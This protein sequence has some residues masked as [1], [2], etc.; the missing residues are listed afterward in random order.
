MRRIAERGG[1]PPADE[2]VGTLGRD[3][4]LLPLEKVLS[5]GSA[6]VLRGSLPGSRLPPVAFQGWLPGRVTGLII[7]TF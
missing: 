4:L 3:Q 7:F 2:V 5:V 6:G 1:D